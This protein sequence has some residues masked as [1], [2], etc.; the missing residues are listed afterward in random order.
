MCPP[1]GPNTRMPG[2]GNP[3]AEAKRIITKALFTNGR[4]HRAA[5]ERGPRAE[6]SEALIGSSSSSPTRKWDSARWW[7]SVLTTQKW[8]QV[9]IGLVLTVGSLVALAGQIRRWRVG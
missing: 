5:S 1:L 8:T 4:P 2:R 3:R 7:P 9:D 6:A